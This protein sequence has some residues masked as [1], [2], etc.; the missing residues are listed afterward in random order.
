MPIGPTESKPIARTASNGQRRVLRSGI[1]VE[2]KKEQ[3]LETLTAFYSILG[4][5]G[6][7]LGTGGRIS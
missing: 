3:L 4:E 2:V 7:P 1:T 6:H 5:T